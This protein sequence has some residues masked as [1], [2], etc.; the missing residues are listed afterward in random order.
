VASQYFVTGSRDKH[1]KVW[2]AQRWGER[3]S[4]L[5]FD[6]AVTAVATERHPHQPDTFVLAVGLERFV[7]ARTRAASLARER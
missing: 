2:K 5:S 4:E 6:S 3:D 1:I 7:A